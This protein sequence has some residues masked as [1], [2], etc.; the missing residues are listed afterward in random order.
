MLS[1]NPYI[2]VTKIFDSNM[3]M[4]NCSTN[5]S[6][7]R[8]IGKTYLELLHE[9]NS[10]IG[11]EKEKIEKKYSRSLIDDLLKEG[12]LMETNSPQYNCNI[13]KKCNHKY[14]LTGVVIE[15]TNACNLNCIHCYGQFGRPKA[16]RIWTLA[17]VKDIK[18]KLDELH[19]MEVRLSGGEC[20]LNSDFE[21]I[22]LFFLNNG[23][24]VGIYS[25]GS[26]PDA[27]EKFLKKT[28]KYNF[29]VAISLD[30]IG[31]M[32]NRMRGRD[33]YNEVIRSLNILK[34]Y[35]NVEVLIETAV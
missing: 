25:N 12:T 16:C 18:R 15:V 23:F 3:Y 34:M 7:C 14:P 17:E 21:E 9:V 28:K 2:R 35:D 13:L 30:G 26:L 27:L 22:A 31:N 32:H 5:A 20:F 11:V 29:Y 10:G 8:E 24:R 19:T 4:L 1:V 6:I 33:C